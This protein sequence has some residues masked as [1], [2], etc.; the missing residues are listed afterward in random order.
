MHPRGHPCFMG[1]LPLPKAMCQLQR[2][3][4]VNRG[5]HG[6]MWKGSEEK[7]GCVR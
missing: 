4:D 6:W 7:E 3:S 1:P 2:S 5:E